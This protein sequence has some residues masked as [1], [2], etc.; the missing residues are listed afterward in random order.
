MGVEVKLRREIGWKDVITA[1]CQFLD[2]AVIN[3]YNTSSPLQYRTISVCKT[4]LH[5]LCIIKDLH[6]LG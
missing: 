4:Y 2:A 6:V 3:Y 1:K 5:H